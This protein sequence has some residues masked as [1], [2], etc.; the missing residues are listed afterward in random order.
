M[1][2]KALNN[3]QILMRDSVL[4][5]AH[6]ELTQFKTRADFFEYFVALQVMKDYDLDEDEIM[7]G[8][9]G[10]GGDGGCDAMY[11]LYNDRLMNGDELDEFRPQKNGR[12][13]VVIIQAKEEYSF[14]ESALQKWKDISTNLLNFSAAE[15]DY[16]ARYVK[17]VL[18]HFNLFLSLYQSTIRVP[19][20][21]SIKYVYGSLGIEKDIHPNVR[22]QGDELVKIAREYLPSA[23]VTVDYVGAGRLMAMQQKSAD[24]VFALTMAA[25]PIAMGLH[26]DYVALVRLSEFFKFIADGEGGL[27]NALF[28]A[29]VRDYQGL[30]AVNSSIQETLRNKQGED[31]WWLNNGITVLAQKITPKTSYQIQIEEPKIVNGMQTSTEIY[32]YFVANLQEAEQDNRCVL[33]RIIA[34]E[35]EEACDRVIFATN[36]QTNIPKTALRVTDP[37]H[38]QIELYLKTKGLYYDRRKNFYRNQGKKAGDIVSVS[39]LGQ[40]MTSI[41]LWKPNYARARPSTILTNNE[42]YAQLYS[43]SLDLNVYYCA[44][45]IGKMVSAWMWQNQS[46]TRSQITDLLFYVIYGT[47]AFYAENIHPG[48]D[49]IL[50][51]DIKKIDKAKVDEITAVVKQEYLRLGGNDKVAKGSKLVDAV[52]SGI[53]KLLTNKSA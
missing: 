32:H 16:S 52:V 5:P 43:E 53:E 26:S 22:A 29:N 51:L 38:L 42:A 34:P 30:N 15:N 45:M 24:R 37:V 35:N 23:V 50:K 49:E 1:G 41:L 28:E 40:C 31:F 44:A 17:G 13:E 47:A 8:I 20:S 12:L 9:V 25:P 36:Y 11:I 19:T 14:G 27:R 7:S 10:S 4:S 21:L 48:V 39:F 3:V 33:V 46:L 18:D 6:A 2:K